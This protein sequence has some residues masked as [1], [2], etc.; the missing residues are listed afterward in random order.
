LRQMRNAR[1]DMGDQLRRQ[2]E[3]VRNQQGGMNRQV[4]DD[5]VERI[6]QR[7]SSMDNA[8]F[9]RR[10]LAANYTRASDD[11]EMTE[12]DGFTLSID[13]A[14]AVMNGGLTQGITSARPGSFLANLMRTERDNARRVD[15]LYI[16]VLTRKPT[17]RERKTVLDYVAEQGN[18]AATWEDILF[19]LIA[20]TEFATNK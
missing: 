9:L 8:W 3:R 17:E 12:V 10:S 7:L 6:S 1:G 13:Q 5:A 15:E 18:D 11:D 16:R 2:A 19:A 14:L 20:T 4:N